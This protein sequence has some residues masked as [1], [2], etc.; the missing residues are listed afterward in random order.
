MSSCNE[1]ISIRNSLFSYNAESNLSLLS[2]L[3][4]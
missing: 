2:V 1:V 4:F 3:N